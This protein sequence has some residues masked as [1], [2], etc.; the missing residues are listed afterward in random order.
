M[1]GKVRSILGQENMN[2]SF[3]SVGKKSPRQHAVMA[4]SV[5]EEPSQATLQ[6]LGEI[7]AVEEFV[8]LKV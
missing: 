7:P 3:M 6:K 4:I 5:D 1:I 8:F 2:I